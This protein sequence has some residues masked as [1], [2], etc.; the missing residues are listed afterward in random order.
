M[1]L[2]LLE[3]HGIKKLEVRHRKED[4]WTIF[5]KSS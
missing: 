1:S 5:T 2:S 3:A 4:P